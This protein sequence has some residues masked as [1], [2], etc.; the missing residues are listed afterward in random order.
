VTGTE[1]TLATGDRAG[2]S[3]AT[4][5]V[6]AVSD[7]EVD[8]V[9]D[10]GWTRV[11]DGVSLHVAEGETLGL[12]GESGSGKSVTSLAVM[13]L[14]P[15][16]SARV[17]GGSIQLLGEELT[18]ASRSRVED[19]RGE[20]MAMV[21][22]EPMTSLNPAFKIGDQIAQVVRRHRGVSNKLAMQR[23]VEVLDL[24]GIPNAARR[25]RSYP[26]EFSG[27]MRQRVMLAMAIS[28]E[29]KLLIADEP[30][31]AL[32]VTIQA[33]VLDLLRSMRDELGMALLFITHDLGVVADICDRVVV[34]YAGQKIEESPI[35]P[36]Y[37]QPRHPYTEGLLSSMPQIGGLGDRLAS[38]PGTPPVPWEL[39]DGCRFHPRCPYAT[40][41]CRSG[42]IELRPVGEGRT[43]RCVRVGEL[44]LRGTAS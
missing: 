38:I 21:F 27:G 2:R 35:D 16:Q 8:F 42:E 31:T 34:M 22:Q 37:R 29:P 6:L 36:M 41:E 40:D 24:V 3:F 18:T 14:L 13:G 28:C 39:P 1:P 17:A 9:T 43:A 4:D 33:Q 5:T 12:V 25:A 30:T 10:R 11:I 32:D 44:Q 20:S 26:H 15:A 23:A 7:L 19:L